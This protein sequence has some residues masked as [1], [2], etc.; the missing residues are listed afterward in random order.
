MDK[1][2]EN[3]LRRRIQVANKHIKRCWVSLGVREMWIK[4]TI[5]QYFTP[6]G[7]DVIEDG[8]SKCPRECGE[9]V[10]THI[11]CGNVKWRRRFGSQCSSSHNVKEGV[12]LWPRVSI[13]GIY[14]R[15]LK[16]R[17]HT[18]TWLYVIVHWSIIHNSKKKGNLSKYPLS[19]N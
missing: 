16:I 5:G 3:V 19:D 8:D 6:T 18:K 11:A 7:M 17:V 15:G 2:L 4:T 10:D 12:N 13:P 9:T 14:L 1:I